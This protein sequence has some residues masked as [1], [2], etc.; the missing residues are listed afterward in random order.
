VLR[1]PRPGTPE[2]R[3]PGTPE[4]WDTVAPERRIL[5]V[6]RTPAAVN[7]LTDVV[8]LVSEDPR[9]EV[10]YVVDRGSAFSAA[11]DGQLASVGASLLPWD[12]AV[13][14][15]FDLAIAASDNGDLKKILAPLVLLAHG[16]GY[17]RHSAA[18]PGAI[19]GI[20]KSTLV[21]DGRAIPHTLALAHADQVDTVGR[22]DP[23]LA[24][25]TLV[26]GDPCLDR[27]TASLP[28]RRRYR[29]A[30]G[31]T[32]RSLVTICSTWGT[33]SLFGS[34]PKLPENVMKALPADDY[35]VALV[36]H[37]NV[38]ERH[39]SLQIRSWLRRATDAG[40]IVI[41]PDE[42]WRAALVAAD[43]VVSDHGSLTCYAVAAGKP[44]LIASTGGPEVVQDS[45]LA[46]LLE[47]LPGLDRDEPLRGQLE[48]ALARGMN[49]EKF[50]ERMFGNRGL[51]GAVLRRHLYEILDLTEPPGPPPV[52]PLPC[53]VTEFSEPEAFDIVDVVVKPADHQTGYAVL[54]MERHPASLVEP[55]GFDH[56]A[57][58]EVAPD[59]EQL[60]RAAVVWSS[61]PHDD[62]PTALSWTREALARY[63]GA[64][65][66]ITET[67]GELLAGLRNGLIVA[68]HGDLSRSLAGSAVYRWSL[69][70]EGGRPDSLRVNAGAA[71]GSLE[72]TILSGVLGTVR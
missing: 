25:H 5:V 65:V 21:I 41:P 3:N 11:V 16:A 46:Q 27:I 70:P 6:A 72:V 38:W 14:L 71:S 68:C 39:G 61:D 53:P 49:G 52:R 35:R 48:G 10:V 36:L 34:S 55:P 51:A 37:P 33:Q 8:P 31:A 44:V 9:V 13:A 62:L 22:A 67:A 1:Q 4:P 2:P 32:S 20:R 19:S 17:H 57:V 69:M 60:E 63:P 58:C 56:R 50:V 24:R 28:L 66:A 26:I 30:F 64:R 29:R 45:P 47:H 42:G 15:R 23:E 54:T 18:E 59:P 7:R 40:L 12:E 43:L